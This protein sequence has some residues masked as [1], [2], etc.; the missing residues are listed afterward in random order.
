MPWAISVRFSSTDADV[1]NNLTNRRIM[2]RDGARL[3]PQGN[4]TDARHEW[5]VDPSRGNLHLSRDEL[6]PVDAAVGPVEATVP[7]VGGAPDVGAYE[8][9][10]PQ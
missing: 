10:S 5:F 6:P 4:I 7:F 8:Y 1:R 3:A 9:R 2:A